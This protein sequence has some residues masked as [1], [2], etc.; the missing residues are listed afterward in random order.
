M[1]FSRDTYSYMWPRDGALVANALDMAGFSDLA[2]WFYTFCKRRHHRRRL[3]PITSTTP[4][5]RPLQSWHP[6]VLKGN[7][8]LPIQEDETALVVWAMWRHYFRYRDI[9]FIRPLWVDVVQKAADFMVR[10]RDPKHRPAAAELRPVGRALGR[11]RLHRRD[12][13]RR[14]ESGAQLRRLLRRSRKGRELQ[15]APPRK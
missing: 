8:V 10:Y 15:H 12:G 4:T 5:A 11:S 13:V 2:R 14:A 1:Q 9:E 3:L 7:R 6:W